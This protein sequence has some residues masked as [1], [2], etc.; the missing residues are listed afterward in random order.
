MPVIVWLWPAT[1]GSRGCSTAPPPTVLGKRMKRNRQKL[2]G[3]DRGSLTEQQTKGTVTTMIQIRRIHNTNSRTYRD[4]L[5]ARPLPRACSRALTAFLPPRSPP[6]RTQHG[7]T[8]YGIPCS[9][10]PG[11][12]SPPGCVPSWLLLK[13][14]P[15]L[16]EPWTANFRVIEIPY[17]Q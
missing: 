14:N 3:Q 7:G 13:I 12:V 9:V 4:T 5:T 6:A 2:V 8:W 10:W 11:W 15:V 17:D 1:K 16:A